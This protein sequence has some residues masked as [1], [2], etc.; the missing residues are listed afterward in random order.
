MFSIEYVLYKMCSLSSM[1]SIECLLS[2]K[3]ES[4]NDLS[5]VNARYFRERGGV[6]LLNDQRHRPLQNHTEVGLAHYTM[7]VNPV[8]SIHSRCISVYIGTSR[9]KM[10]YTYAGTSPLL[11]PLI[12]STYRCQEHR[13]KTSLAPLRLVLIHFL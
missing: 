8:F 1:S 7:I 3:C 11:T 5:F 13:L 10:P 6:C 12:L 9:S 2:T 4:I